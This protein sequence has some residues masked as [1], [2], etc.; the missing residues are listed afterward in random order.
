LR[1][2]NPMI[3]RITRDNFDPRKDLAGID[4]ALEKGL[5]LK[6]KLLRQRN[7]SKFEEHHYWETHK[8]FEKDTIPP[9]VWPIHAILG[10]QENGQFI[11]KYIGEDFFLNIALAD[12]AATY[13]H[14]G[15]RIYRS[16]EPKIQQGKLNKLVR[17][18]RARIIARRL[19][20]L[21]NQVV[22]EIVDPKYGIKPFAQSQFA[23]LITP[24]IAPT[25]AKAYMQLLKLK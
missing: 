16:E 10:E 15:Q 12:V 22:V 5:A 1:D 19:P 24:I 11:P 18:H 23:G 14:N 8:N 17:E 6:V 3:K 7:Y 21:D 13:S 20:E 9:Y 2:N 4:E 25:F